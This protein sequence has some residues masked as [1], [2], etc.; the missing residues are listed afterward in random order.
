MGPA[1]G[2]ALTQTF[3]VTIAV[4]LALGLGLAFPF[5][6]L[7][8]FPLLTQYLPKPGAWMKTFQQFL[9]FP[10][11]ITTIWLVWVLGLQA[12]VNAIFSMLLA[13][14]LLTFAIWLWQTSSARFRVAGR[15]VSV[16][17]LCTSALLIYWH[18]LQ[19]KVSDPVSLTQSSRSHYQPFSRDTLDVLLSNGDPVFVN[20]TAAWCIT[21]LANEKVA[22]STDALNTY[23]NDNNITYLKGD[24][25]NQDSEIT[26]Y[27]QSFGRNSVPLY[28][29]YPSSR[30]KGVVTNATKNTTKKPI[31]LPQILT[32]DLVIKAL[33]DAESTPSD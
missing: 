28:V 27:L 18:S 21:C 3:V 14:V 10:M 8:F 13:L 16:F 2:F 23:F 24:W 6:L 30:G 9:A 20:M 26:Q 11:F 15:C 31:V 19:A 1:I 33:S 17:A 4:L 22:L 29:Y 32:V 7:S 5:L 25:T 12:G